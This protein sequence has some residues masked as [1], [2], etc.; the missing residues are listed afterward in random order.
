MKDYKKFSDV[1]KHLHGEALTSQE[2][3]LKHAFARSAFNR[4][5]Y[6]SYLEIKR[7]LGRVE[8]KWGKLNHGEISNLLQKNVRQD[9]TKKNKKT[10]ATR[11]EEKSA[12]LKKSGF[13]ATFIDE[14]CSGTL[15]D[16]RELN[17][18]FS[19]MQKARIAADYN[20]SYPV[21]FHGQ[22][23]FSLGVFDVKNIDDYHG[24][25]IRYCEKIANAWELYN[26]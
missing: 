24:Q 19:K 10:L 12:E 7:M 4:Y 17:A 21:I 26:V 25:T 11:I 2:S 23:E 8:K 18:I 13:S 15:N 6:S 1:A 5:Y 20:F 14:I 16:I 22:A 9:P 3:D